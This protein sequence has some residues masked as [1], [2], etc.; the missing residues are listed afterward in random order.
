MKQAKLTSTAKKSTSA[1]VADQVKRRITRKS[2]KSNFTKLKKGGKN[3]LR[4]QQYDENGKLRESRENLCDCFDAECLGCHFECEICG[5][6]KCGNICRRNREFIF[7]TI[8]YDGSAKIVT[9]K[10]FK[11]D[12]A[13][14]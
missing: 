2:K 3:N 1:P 6:Q 9:N 13:K 7:E 4:K 11:A 8:E 14:V 5:S 12:Q 10:Y